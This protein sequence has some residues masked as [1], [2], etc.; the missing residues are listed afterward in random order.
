MTD[1]KKPLLFQQRLYIIATTDNKMKKTKLTL[2]KETIN[3]LDSLNIGFIHMD[4]NFG[5]HEV[6]EKTI[7]WYGGTR[8]D[9]I[10]H[11]SMEFFSPDEFTNLEALDLEFLSKGI[12]QYQFEYNLPNKKGEKIPFL[13]SISINADSQN[14]PVSTNVLL[15][16][17]SEQKKMQVELSEANNS[18][19]LSQTALENEKKMIEA[20]LFGIGDCVTV[21]DKEGNLL[22]SNPMGKEIRGNRTNPL[23][24][25]NPISKKV[26]HLDIAGENRQFTGQVEVIRDSQGKIKAYAEIFKDTTDLFRLEERESEL[27]DIKRQIKR[28]KI[29]TEMLGISPSFT[30]VFDLILRCAEVESTILILGET[31]VGKELA[32]RAIHTQSKRNGKRFVAVNCGSI[33]EA[34]LES[35]L[36]GHEKGAFTGAVSSR[37]GLFR[38]AEGGTLFLDEVGDLNILLQVKLLRALQEKEIRPVGGTHTFPINVRIISATNR[39][40]TDLIP[41]GL[42]REDLY[43]RLAVIP[44]TIPPL[45]ER[46]DDIL[47]LAEH[48]INKHC[49]QNNMPRKQLNAEARQFLLAYQW[50]GNIRELENSIEYAVAM[51]SGSF[52][53][54]DDFPL[55][56]AAIQN[57][58][59]KS[60]GIHNNKT[61]ELTNVALLP[62]QHVL[63][64]LKPWE[65]E[66]RQRIAE[67]LNKCRDNRSEAAEMLGVSRSTLWRKIKM[68]HI[69]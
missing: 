8:E 7:E 14:N 48:F 43:Y 42:F 32:A 45:R 31:G 38:E 29:K 51:S 6:N 36:F 61:Q 5:I 4:G 9:L 18:L 41:K 20:I 10:G 16:N 21:F 52:L 57:S 56:I 40:L 69:G 68:Y 50:P 49:D 58:L 44:L 37:I 19:S 3:L 65:I 67:M 27:R 28:E 59:N 46:P 12:K 66:E 35:E 34:L 64:Q 63:Q 23:L 54:P 24:D 11:H 15:T 55:Q 39:K 60:D 62:D 47:Y 22:L 13:L 53:N 30:K 2:N 1:N 17:I 33:P 25:L 26:L